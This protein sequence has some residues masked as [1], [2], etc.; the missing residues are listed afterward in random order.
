MHEW[1]VQVNVSDVIITPVCAMWILVRKF[2][3]A[4]VNQRFIVFRAVATKTIPL[5]S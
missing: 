5:L 1:Y 2:V 3:S 4:L